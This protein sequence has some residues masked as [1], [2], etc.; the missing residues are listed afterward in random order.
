MSKDT[1]T[2]DVEIGSVKKPKSIS[3]RY[4]VGRLPY[5]GEYYQPDD[6]VYLKC[7]M[8]KYIK[9]LEV[10]LERREARNAEANQD[11]I[12]LYKFMEHAQSL[13]W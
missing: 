2:I 13:N 11:K 7:D 1:I 4:F 3:A 12:I 10:K 8:D 9:Y 6:R 5:I